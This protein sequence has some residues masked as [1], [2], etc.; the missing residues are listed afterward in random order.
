MAEE[1]R[2]T[3]P[4]PFVF[5]LMPFAKEFGDVYEIGIKEAADKAGAYAERVDEQMF[6][7]GMLERVYNQINKADVLVADM[8]GC[9]P[10]VFYEVGYAHALGKIVVLLARDA[11][12]IPFDLQHRQH[13]IYDNVAQLREQLAERLLWALEE[14]KKRSLPAAAERFGVSIGDTEVPESPSEDA[15]PAV[16]MDVNPDR[17]GFEL[18]VALRNESSVATPQVEFVYLF[19]QREPGLIPATRLREPAFD[20][21]YGLEPYHAMHC[22]RGEATDALV[23]QFRLPDSIPALPPGAAHQLV[24]AFRFRERGKHA[25]VS[26]KLRLHTS[27]NIHDFP[28]HLIPT[29]RG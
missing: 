16:W 12:S 28:F 24:V 1:Y 4:K 6:L 18:A 7:E 9:N 5:V 23:E 29:P 11:A 21:P 22:P 3:T 25:S 15:G 19:A 26:L 13:L 27:A 17:W 14:S 10:N 20:G 2:R 8:T